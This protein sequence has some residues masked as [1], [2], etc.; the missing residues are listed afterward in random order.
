MSNFNKVNLLPDTKKYSHE[1]QET[2]LKR[3]ENE[4]IVALERDYDFFD[5]ERRYGYGGYVN[6][7]RWDKIALKF[8]KY[9]QLDIAAKILQVECEKGFLLK[10]FQNC[11]DNFNLVGTES[12]EYAYSHREISL[13]APIIR[14]HG[15]HLPFFDS[16]FDLVISIGYPY[17]LNLRDFSIF[18]HELKRISRQQ[19]ITLASYQSLEELSMFRKW[20]L[21]GNLIKTEKEWEDI[22][23]SL[24]YVGAVQFVSALSLGLISRNDARGS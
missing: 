5:G 19:F 15:P 1:R 10:A 4:K 7:G 23:S 6:D 16:S 3:G 24:Q 8:V 22:L 13:K 12:S 17:T 11:N 21:L 20:S 2:L 14:N 18:I 9:F